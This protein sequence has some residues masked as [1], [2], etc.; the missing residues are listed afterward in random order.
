MRR[1]TEEEE[2]NSTTAYAD[3]GSAGGNVFSFGLPESQAQPSFSFAVPTPVSNTINVEYSST[4]VVGRGRGTHM[5]RPS[6]MPS[7]GH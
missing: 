5:L 4:P 7:N 6:W 1:P 2:K 3:D